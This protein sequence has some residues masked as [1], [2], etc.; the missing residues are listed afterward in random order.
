MIVELNEFTLVDGTLYFRGNGG[1]LGRAIFEG[2]AKEEIKN[3]LNLS[4]GDNDISLC[5]SLQRQ[6]LLLPD[7]AK[8]AAKCSKELFEVSRVPRHRGV[9]VRLRD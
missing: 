7:T 3:V 1:I 8:D 2:K 6:G 9:S 4:Y 5:R